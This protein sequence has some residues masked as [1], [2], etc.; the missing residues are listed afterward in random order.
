MDHQLMIIAVPN[1]ASAHEYACIINTETHIGVTF[2][3]VYPGSDNG[4][5][6]N[7]DHRDVRMEIQ[8]RAKYIDTEDLEMLADAIIVPKG[9]DVLVLMRD[10]DL[11]ILEQIDDMFPQSEREVLSFTIA[12]ENLDDDPWSEDSLRDDESTTDSFSGIEIIRY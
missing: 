4:L 10:P 11:D 7:N 2:N 12:D 5:L 3:N 9:H 1:N 6:D 8:Y